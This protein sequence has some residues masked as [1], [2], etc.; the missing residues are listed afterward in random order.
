MSTHSDTN[1]FQQQEAK[2][3]QVVNEHLKKTKV[4]N[5]N[6]LFDLHIR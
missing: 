1:F 6:V 4:K 5:N 3:K 2:K